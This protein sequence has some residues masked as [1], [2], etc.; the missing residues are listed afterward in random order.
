M[1]YLLTNKKAG[2]VWFLFWTF[3]KYISVPL[4]VLLWAECWPGYNTDRKQIYLRT[5]WL[6]GTLPIWPWK[7]QSAVC[8][9][10]KYHRLHCGAVPPM[11]P[12]AVPK[13]ALDPH[14]CGYHRRMW[15][16]LAGNALWSWESS[17]QQVHRMS[18]G[19]GGATDGSNWHQ[20]KVPF[21]FSPQG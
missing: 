16:T 21:I 8:H 17:L 20:P 13:A 14:H 12:E 15:L 2:I 9:L 1:K 18:E 11:Q 5:N 10:P 4:I 19:Q 3:T 6:P 7:K